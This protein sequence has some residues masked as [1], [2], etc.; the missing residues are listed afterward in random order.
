M[1]LALVG[2]PGCGKSTLGRQLARRLGLPFIDA[3]AEIE[4]RI[5]MPI[6]QYFEMEGEAAFREIETQAVEE[7]CRRDE[8]VLA[9]GGGAVLKPQNREVLS[10]CCTV[11]YLRANPEDLCGASGM[12]PRGRCSRSRTGSRACRSLRTNVTSLYSE[13]ADFVI[14]TGHPSPKTILNMIAM[15][16]EL[17]QVAGTGQF[18]PAAAG[19]NRPAEAVPRLSPPSGAGSELPEAHLASSIGQSP[20]NRATEGTTFERAKVDLGD[21]AYEITIDGKLLGEPL[22]FGAIPAGGVAAIV[23]NTTVD[24]LYG[25]RLAATLA[26]RHRKLIR[27]VLPDG[28]LHKDWASLDQIFDA[29]LRNASIANRRSSRSAAASSAT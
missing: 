22:T 23:T 2:L 29:L 12:T 21:R 18:A 16:I 11:V 26:S 8:F 10:R 4:S 13:V 5:G 9:T 6:R 7:L 25:D 24:P 1:R 19:A 17:A 15:Q 14:E 27:V 28:D 20:S 3:D